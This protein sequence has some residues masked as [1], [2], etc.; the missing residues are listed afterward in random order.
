MQKNWTDTPLYTIADWVMKL[1]YINLLWF[2]FTFLGLIIL[3]FFPATVAMFTILRQM[4]LKEDSVPIFKT[5]LT[6]IKQEF[7]RANAV[8]LMLAVIGY[9]IYID[10][11]YL[12]TVDGYLH[13]ILSVVFIVLSIVY[14]AVCLMIIPVLVHFEL[15][16]SQ[17][18]K[19]AILF[20]VINPHIMIFMGAGIYFAYRLFNFL[21]GLTLFFFGSLIS[22]FIM[23][24][25]TLA[26]NRVEKKQQ[27]LQPSEDK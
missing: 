18:F 3:G 9:I 15:S 17:Y 27:R 12:G 10:F 26:F 8:G 6:V 13:S 21:P 20:S 25:A 7:V 23:W 1:A 24:S 5:F 14:G 11:L 22:L 4:L 19:H 16:F 2:L